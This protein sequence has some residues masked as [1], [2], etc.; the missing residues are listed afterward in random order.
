MKLRMLVSTLLVMLLLLVPTVNG[1]T[2]SVSSPERTQGLVAPA[3][4]G[5]HQLGLSCVT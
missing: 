4:Q 5:D 3:P 2:D 1:Y